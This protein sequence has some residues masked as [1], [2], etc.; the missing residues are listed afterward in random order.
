MAVPPDLNSGSAAPTAEARESR[1][2]LIGLSGSGKSTVGRRLA[3]RLG[4]RFFDT[5][6]VVRAKAQQSIAEI[7][8]RE[9]WDAFRRL[10]CAVLDEALSV[11]GV[12]V[13]TGGGIVEST[14]AADRIAASACVVWLRAAV[15]SLLSRLTTDTEARPLLASQPE[16]ALRQ[17]ARRREPLYS[18]LADFA[19]DTEGCDVEEVAL[20]IERVMRK[21][22]R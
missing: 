8:Q 17:M 10:E 2:V 19:V 11:E 20:R 13:A 22:A 21:R 16:Q 5:D 18:R 7:V 12:V 15:R 4:R 9:G 1:I 6:A 3:Q 14:D